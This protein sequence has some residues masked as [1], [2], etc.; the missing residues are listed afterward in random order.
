M[1]M[2]YCHIFAVHCILQLWHGAGS[3]NKNVGFC[4]SSWPSDQ[5]ALQKRPFLYPQL[6][7]CK[8]PGCPN[9]KTG[10]ANPKNQ[11]AKSKKG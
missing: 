10:V 7:E 11:V 8:K 5:P 4:S 2:T 1:P 9:A 3:R 6:A